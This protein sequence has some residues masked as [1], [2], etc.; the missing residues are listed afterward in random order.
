MPGER[1]HCPFPEPEPLAHLFHGLLTM[2]QYRF[3]FRGERLTEVVRCRT[4]KIGVSGR[5]PGRRFER[6]H[7][8][9]ICGSRLFPEDPIRFEQLDREIKRLLA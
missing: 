6:R 2:G 3:S 8:S 1:I 4:G 5:R 7:G 9:L